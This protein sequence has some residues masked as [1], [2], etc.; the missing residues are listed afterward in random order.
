[1][2]D[3]KKI[4]MVDDDKMLLKLYEM[5]VEAHSEEFELVTAENTREGLEL[6]EKEH[7]DVI[8]LDLILGKKPGTPVDELDKANGFNFLLAVK[9]D[10]NTK[11]IPVIVFS[12]LDT[13]KD[14]E[15][16][17]SLGASDYIV[18]AKTSPEQVLHQMEEVIKLDKAAWQ[19]QDAAQ[20]LNSRPNP[21]LD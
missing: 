7:P 13:R 10:P 9:G 6:A 8:L 5:A 20:A 17:T 4:L 1:M 2:P 18:K 11:R 19:V 12:N 3:I 21:P 14:H 15:K 16:A